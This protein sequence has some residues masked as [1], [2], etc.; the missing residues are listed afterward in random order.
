[1]EQLR[2]YVIS[3]VSAAILVGILTGLIHGKDGTGVLLR[4][5]AG[6]FLT[7]TVVRPVVSLEFGNL[8]AYITAFSAEG[9]ASVSEG[10]KLAHDAYCSYIK[11]RMEAYILDKAEAYGAELSVE[12]ELNEE[13]AAEPVAARIQ[14]TVSPY[15][16]ITL[17][18]I[19]EEELGILKENQLWIG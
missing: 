16:K 7:F 4:L 15:T 12:V 2:A 5:I 17:Q 14:G 8:E 6:L 9:A 1:M 10:E 19:M 3:V 11:S 13:V 18:R